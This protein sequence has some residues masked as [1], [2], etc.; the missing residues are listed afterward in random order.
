MSQEKAWAGESD[1]SWRH[2]TT[3]KTR[4]RGGLDKEVR[5]VMAGKMNIWTL[6]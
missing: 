5:G 1:E 4:V 3:L 6:F 2:P